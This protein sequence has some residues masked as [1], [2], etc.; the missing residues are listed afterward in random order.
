LGFDEVGVAR[1]DLPLREEMDRYEA[2]LQAG[3]HGEMGYLA[4]HAGV[5]R[6]LDTKDILE[7]ARSV[8]CLARRYPRDANEEGVVRHVARYARGRD[9]HNFLRKKLRRLAAFLRTL[10]GPDGAEVEARPLCDDVPVLERAWAARAGLGFVG[11]N[12]LLI[13]PGGGSFV[14]LGEVVTT[15]PLPAGEPLEERCGSCRA[16]L[17]ACPTEAFPRAFVLDARRCIAYLTIELRGTIAEPDRPLVG[18][19]LFGCDDCQTV[20]P[21]NASARTRKPSGDGPFEPADGLRAASMAGLLTEEGCKAVL[22]PG[23]PLLRTGAQGLARNA[24]LVLGNRRQITALGALERAAD[25]HSSAV[26]REAARWAVG[27]MKP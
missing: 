5:R 15:L 17:D 18:E 25:G 7:G 9:Y 3:M 12:G 11:K 26:V 22:P 6:R 21:F 24:A 19:H 14:L 1:A 2:F 23:S 13:V 10:P 16:C 20:C 8:V 4:E 27:Q